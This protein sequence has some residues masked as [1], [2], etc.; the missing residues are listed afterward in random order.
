I[1]ITYPK[2]KKV[3]GVDIGFINF[4]KI[5]KTMGGYGELV[6]DIKDLTPSLERAFKSGLPSVINVKTDP[7]AVSGAT[8]VI[9]QMMMKGM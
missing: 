9:T 5:V 6:E 8:H 7:D 3:Q 1:D 4:H 2:V